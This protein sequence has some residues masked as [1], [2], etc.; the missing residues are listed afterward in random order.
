MVGEHSTGAKI[1]PVDEQ[2]IALNMVGAHGTGAKI[3]PVDEQV[4]ALN[5]VTPTMGVI[6]LSKTEEPELFG[7]AKVGLGGLGVVTELTLQCVPRHELVEKTFTVSTSEVKKNHVKWLQDNQHL[8]YMWIPYTDSVVV[9]QCNPKGSPAADSA[10]AGSGKA[11]PS[12]ADAL[13]PLRMNKAEA[14]FWKLSSGTRVGYSDEILGFDCGGQQWVLETAFPV[15][16][17]L[18]ALS[19]QRTKDLE[20][21]ETLLTEIKKNKIPAPSPIEQRW[22]SGSS[23]PMSPAAGSP[24]SVHSWVGTIMYLPEEAEARAKITESF[25]SYAG[26]VQDRV[27]PKY[28][29]VWHWAKLEVPTSPCELK[30]VRAKLAA[31]YPVKE[32]NA[33]RTLL[34]PRNILANEW[35][36]ALFPK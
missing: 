35:L 2:V 12:Q 5:L 1:P 25:R 13:K 24:E 20:Y 28:G 16:S 31:R 11:P 19:G 4:I 33:Y 7:I 10:A 36:D 23:S 15:G 22:T 30:S 18:S 8:R 26:M 21:M 3:P 29:A 6:K 17:S 9:V 32:Y 34:D 27:M 14:E